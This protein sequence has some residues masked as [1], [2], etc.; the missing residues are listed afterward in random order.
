LAR[1]HITCDIGTRDIKKNKVIANLK[2][3]EFKKE[4]LIYL[5]HMINGGE[6][7]VDSNK[8]TTIN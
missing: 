8:I 5:G 7:R 3:R 1:A 2:K 4:T 6:L